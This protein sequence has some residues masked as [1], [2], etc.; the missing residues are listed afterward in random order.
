MRDP[1]AGYTWAYLG[2]TK[3][4]VFAAASLIFCSATVL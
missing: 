4:V 1:L 3:A 2:M